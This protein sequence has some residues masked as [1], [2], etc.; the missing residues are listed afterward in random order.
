[1]ATTCLHRKIG[2]KESAGGLKR[3]TWSIG[4]SGRQE[5][6]AGS[7]VLKVL[8][9]QCGAATL[10]QRPATRLQRK[11]DMFEMCDGEVGLLQ[12]Y[13]Q[14]HACGSGSPTAP[15]GPTARF[16]E[17]TDVSLRLFVRSF[18]AGLSCLCPKALRVRYYSCRT[19]KNRSLSPRRP[20]LIRRRRGV[21]L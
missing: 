12:C 10:N 16:Q 7:K 18:P 13:I 11:F 6:T 14:T 5:V 9:P 17:W 4:G 1:M 21:L 20:R 2:A 19:K 3:C 8:R 15:A